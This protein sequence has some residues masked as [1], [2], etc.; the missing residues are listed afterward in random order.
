M[1]RF[2]PSKRYVS[3]TLI[4]LLVLVTRRDGREDVLK[5]Q[6]Y[7]VEADVPFLCGKR[8]LELWNFKIDGLEKLLEVQIDGRQKTFDMVDT[9]GNHY[10]IVLE[11]R[12]RNMAEILFME[13]EEGDLCSYKAVRKVHEVNHH[14]GKDKLIGAYRNAGWMSPDLTKIITQVVRDFKVCEKF[15]KSVSRPRV[16]LPKSTSFNEVVTLDLKEFGSK[17]VL[18][19]IR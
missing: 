7:L 15:S 17:Y 11:T 18:W 9:K 10:G 16:T 13:D 3:Q 1:F 8:T 14:K 12:D 5:V 19:M 2:G 4:E 6:T